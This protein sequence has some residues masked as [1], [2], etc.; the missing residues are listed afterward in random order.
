MTP[1]IG[2]SSRKNAMTL[3]PFTFKL[4][5]GYTTIPVYYSWDGATIPR[6]GWTIVGLTPFGAH[7]VATLKHDY[8]YSYEGV[9]PGYPYKLTRKF[10]D[11]MLFD[12]L[13]NLGYKGLSLRVIK[14]FVRIGGYYFWREF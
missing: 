1:R 6:I 5:D 14:F 4:P 11:N 7:N 10:V 9:I 13:A 2:Y 3:E 12:D 8:L